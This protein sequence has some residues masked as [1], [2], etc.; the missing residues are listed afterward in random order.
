MIEC[1]KRK[2]EGLYIN[3]YFGIY[4]F[5]GRGTKYLENRVCDFF[6][7]FIHIKSGKGEKDR[8]AAIDEN[9]IKFIKEYLSK[10]KRIRW[11]LFISKKNTRITTIHTERLIKYYA[12]KVGIKKRITP[13]TIRHTFTTTLLRNRA[14]IRFIQQILGQSSIATTQTYTHIDEDVLKQVYKRTKPHY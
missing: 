5:K 6:E 7:N 8:L 11:Y 12:K 14:D 2:L 3:S 10:E 13:H 4:R 1:I 9:V